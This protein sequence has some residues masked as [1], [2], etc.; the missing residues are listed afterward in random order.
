MNSSQLVSLLWLGDRPYPNAGAFDGRGLQS[1]VTKSSSCRHEGNSRCSHGRSRRRRAGRGSLGRLK[2][3]R[4]WRVLSSSYAGVQTAHHGRGPLFALA[5]GHWL[6]APPRTQNV[7]DDIR[8]RRT[9]VSLEC[10]VSNPTS[11][12]MLSSFWLLEGRAGSHVR[13]QALQSDVR[14]RSSDGVVDGDQV[15]QTRRSGLAHTGGTSARRIATHI[16][17]D[18]VVLEVERVLLDVD[19]GN[20]REERVRR[21]DGRDLELL[22]L[23]V[24]SS[25]P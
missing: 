8:Q 10:G 4:R 6:L 2:R 21:Q 11:G 25:S 1:T 17:L 12:P 22:G 23:R 18:G 5:M 3:A 19:D 24:V 13:L 16:S 7:C 14:P 15:L 20:G 9:A